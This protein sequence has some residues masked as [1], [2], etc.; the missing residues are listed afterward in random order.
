MKKGLIFATTLA[1]ALGVGVAVGAHQQKAAKV[2][3]APVSKIYCKNVQSWWTDAGATV[4]AYCWN[5]EDESQKNANWPGVKMSEVQGQEGL[6][7]YDVPNGYD[8]VIFTRLNAAGNE[9]WGA[10]TDDQDIPSVKNCFT[11]TSDT[12]QWEG[13]GH[14]AQGNWS[15]YPAVS[16]EY[17]LLGTFNDWNDSDDEYILTVDP[18]DANKYTFSGVVLAAN[19]EVKVCDVK[20]DDWYGDHGGNVVAS[21]AG[22]Y[23]VDFYVHADNEINVVLHKQEV[24]PVYTIKVLSNEPVEFVLDEDGKPE[25]VVHQYSA[26][27][28]FAS[29]GRRLR[30]YRDGVELTS[31][32]GV[33][34]DTEHD[35]PVAGNNVYGDT[36]NGFYCASTVVFPG[37]TKF[38]LKTYS[39]GGLSVWGN[40]YENNEFTVEKM[41]VSGGSVSSVELALDQDYVANETYVRQY[42]SSSA[43]SLKALP[44]LS[45]DD[46]FCLKC[47]GLSE[48]IVPEEGATNNARAAFQSICWKVHNDCEEVIYVKEKAA[49]LSLV[50]YVGGYEDAHVLTI[51]GKDVALSKYDENQYVAHGVALSAGDTVTKYT[52]E[53]E[54]QTITSRATVNNNLTKEMKILVDVA[55]ADIYFNTQDN[56]LYVSGLPLEGQHIL[57]NGTTLIEMNPTDPYEGY[58]QYCSIKLSFAVNDTIKFIDCTGANPEAEGRALVWTISKIAEGGLGDHFEY[59]SEHQ[60][61]KCKTACETAVYMK[62]KSGL[63][64]IYFG[65][66][67]EWVQEVI[68]FADGF[69][70]A[71]AG[72]CSTEGKEAKKAAV[73]AKWAEQTAAFAELSDDAKNELKLGESSSLPEVQDFAER[74]I[75]IKQQHSDWT[76]TNFLEWE[77]PSN[78]AY[79]GL[80]LANDGNYGTLIVIV[81]AISTASTI[82]LG[83]LLI[84]KKRKHQ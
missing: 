31:G 34:W 51:G 20:N 78:P 82:A 74:Y 43:V 3:A 16:P 68:D 6:W 64:E 72:A 83:T 52:I 26:E 42:K 39:D 46:S 13:E 22:T 66:V 48:D 75:S 24:E 7:S 67:A 8:R 79:Q 76:L 65:A 71:M 27:V 56:T 81:I 15:V 60:Q 9:Y 4:G 55:S 21:E 57:K 25:G 2:E 12:A 50:I 84:I 53:G 69:E 18:E 47:K 41:D 19:A 63:D 23:D 80:E 45:W 40:G 11:I 58:N 5:S 37:L 35:K 44:G 28:P 62:L 10:K 29:R 49:D 1:M 54:E 70:S 30:F 14:T 17:H 73:E 33:D 61:L 77:I 32:I 59:D 36:T 38:Y